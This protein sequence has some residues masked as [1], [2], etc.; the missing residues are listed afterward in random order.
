MGVLDAD[1]EW[2]ENITN[3]VSITPDK[4]KWLDATQVQLTV[5]VGLNDTS[6]IPPYPGQKGKNRFTIAR[7]WV[8]DMESFA[9]ENGLES[10]ITFEMIPGKGHSMTNLIPYCQEALFA[11]QNP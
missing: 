5:I 3:H 7:N 10:Q 2:D 4:Q 1:I 8:K 9:Q 11:G 6:E